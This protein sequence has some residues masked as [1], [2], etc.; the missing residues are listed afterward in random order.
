MV[1]LAQAGYFNPR[2]S[3][4]ERRLTSR[5]TAE[6]NKFQSTLLMRGATRPTAP[7]RS[8]KG[9]FNPR[10][11]CEERRTFSL[12]YS[13][14]KDFN[15]RSSCEE[16]QFCQ[17]FLLIKRIFQST[18]LMRGATLQSA[19]APLSASISIHAP[20]ARS[21]TTDL[22]SAR[23]LFISIHA[24]HARSD[25][26]S[27]AGNSYGSISIHAPHARS[28][29]GKSITSYCHIQISIH[30]PH[31]RSDEL[32]RQQQNVIQEFQSTLLMRGATRQLDQALDNEEFQST[33]LMRGATPRL[34]Q[35]KRPPNFNPRSSCEERPGGITSD[36]V[37][38]TFQSTLLMRG[39]TLAV[40]IRADAMQFQSTL[41][42]RGATW[43]LPCSL[44]ATEDFN[45]RSS[46]EERRKRL[47][48][49]AG[50]HISIHAPHARSDASARTSSSRSAHFNPR[51]SCEE[52]HTGKPRRAAHLSDF[53]PRSSCEERLCHFQALICLTSS[54]IFRE[55][56]TSFR[57]HFF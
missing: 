23:A 26:T 57:K 48:L 25:Y 5:C 47:R 27:V 37:V 8:R 32:Q 29:T 16:R 51:S 53:N 39:A 2:S 10:S 12:C 41:L 18:L 13:I 20:H 46:C 33:L 7:P 1:V 36:V 43:A 34:W 44:A 35:Q 22:C 17:N 30:A 15:P 6:E 55:P 56:L 3:C 21:D 49:S 38:Y 40:E 28:D 4:E 14:Y 9:H 42:M 19:R 50:I 31:A 54:Y 24:P 11:S 52:R 45:P